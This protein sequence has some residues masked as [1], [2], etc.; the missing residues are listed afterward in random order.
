MNL[1]QTERAAL[2]DL[3]DEV[4]PDAP[5]LCEG[6]TTA[7][8]AAHL[9]VRE[10][11]PIAAGGI[12]FK[13]L[14]GHTEKKMNEELA[15]RPWVEVVAKLRKG[16]TGASIF[17]LPWIDESANSAEMFIHHEDVRR[18]QQPALP[19]RDLDPATED[20]LW[21]RVRM[22]ARALLRRVDTGLVLARN[23]VQHDNPAEEQADLIR[24]HPGQELVTV[25][26]RPSELMLFI[27]G[28]GEHAEVELVGT[29]EAIAKLR[30][31]RVQL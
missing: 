18:A 24:V 20:Q 1:A 5:T 3:L 8:L 10:N 17:R 9:W 30:A 12:L 6:W 16:P 13:P 4:G 25:L 7:D 14:A 15:G 28:R 21:R 22:M 11:D 29:D 23:D 27:S 2:C 19:P 31:A 26:G